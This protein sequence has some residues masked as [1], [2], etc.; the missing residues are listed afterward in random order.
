MRGRSAVRNNDLQLDLFGLRLPALQAVDSALPES[1][2]ALVSI[3]VEESSRCAIERSSESDATTVRPPTENAVDNIVVRP[4][5]SS[6]PE[7]PRN[8]SNYRITDEDRVGVG[9]L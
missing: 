2:E 4:S 5:P 1:R 3:P 6:E 9:S 7:P 8:Q